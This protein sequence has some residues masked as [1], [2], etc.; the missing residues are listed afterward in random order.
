MTVRVEV[1]GCECVEV[2]K[3]FNNLNVY[4]H[5]RGV[6]PQ[7]DIVLKGLELTV[8]LIALWIIINGTLS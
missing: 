2:D 1:R 8:P 6:G 5:S 7:H 4:Y 3:L